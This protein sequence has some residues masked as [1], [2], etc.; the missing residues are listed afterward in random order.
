MSVITLCTESLM[1]LLY[2][3]NWEN[4]SFIYVGGIR[5]NCIPKIFST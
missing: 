3:F 4:D 5:D 2:S 1:N